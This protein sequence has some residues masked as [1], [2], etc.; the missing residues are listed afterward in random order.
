MYHPHVKILFDRYFPDDIFAVEYSTIDDARMDIHV[1]GLSDFDI[2]TECLHVSVCKADKVE[3]RVM[4]NLNFWVTI[5]SFSCCSHRSEPRGQIDTILRN[6]ICIM[7]DLDSEN[8]CP[9]DY[10]LK[11]DNIPSGVTLWNDDNE[12]EGINMLVLYTLEHGKSRFNELGFS[13]NNFPRNF[14]KYLGSPFMCINVSRQQKQLLDSLRKTLKIDDH[15]L[16][17]VQCVF[18]AIAN[19]IR[20]LNDE[21][22]KSF[23]EGTDFDMNSD[24]ICLYRHLIQVQGEMCYF[25]SMFKNFTFKMD[26][27]MPRPPPPLP[28]TTTRRGSKNNNLLERI[29]KEHHKPA[30]APAPVRKRKFNHDDDGVPVSTKTNYVKTFADWEAEQHACL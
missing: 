13:E 27:Q 8:V 5:I 16:P 10:Y 22:D 2:R 23:D 29:T 30:F 21:Y 20:E 3:A 19:R 6:V 25:K 4:F 14:D 28:S 15:P 12:I 26:R 17:S 24:E 18:Q 1:F 7:Q 11:M 9:G